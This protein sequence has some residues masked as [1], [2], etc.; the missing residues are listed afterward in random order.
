MNHNRT[1][2]E[3]IS[4]MRTWSIR[5]WL[6]DSYWI[7]E[8]QER[9]NERKRE[10]NLR[11]KYGITSALYNSILGNQ[12]GLCAICCRANQELSVDH[13]HLT[14]EVRGLLCIRCNRDV[15]IFEMRSE[16]LKTYLELA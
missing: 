2:A 1:F 10:W 14:G 12:L 8:G 3:W 15:G 4:N 11:T 16:E 7:I 6:E 5:H 13:N 9:R